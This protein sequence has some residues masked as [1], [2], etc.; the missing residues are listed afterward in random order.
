MYFWPFSDGSLYSFYAP[1]IA[2][3]CADAIDTPYTTTADVFNEMIKAAST[4]SQMFGPLWFASMYCH[5][6]VPV[7]LFIT[8]L[9]FF[10][11]PDGSN[12]LTPSWYPGRWP[13][14]AVERYKGPWNRKLANKILIIG[15]K[16]D[17][18]TPLASAK[19]L[20]ELLGPRSAV[21]LERDGYG[22]SLVIF[23]FPAFGVPLY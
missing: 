11:I 4:V 7:V 1:S 10:C 5:R 8:K 23:T 3:S 2:I 16:G 9:P 21:L 19:K 17:P 15:N 20:A 18:I 6:C 14:R 22:V 13:A 12:F